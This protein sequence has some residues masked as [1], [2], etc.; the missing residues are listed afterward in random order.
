MRLRG[1]LEQNLRL[2]CHDRGLSVERLAELSGVSDSYCWRILR[3]KA[4]VGLDQVD[5]LATA[6]DVPA[7][8]LLEEIP[9]GTVMPPPLKRGRKKKNA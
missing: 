3:L 4:S 2:L 8:R 9:A 1:I 7:A 6:L 5:K